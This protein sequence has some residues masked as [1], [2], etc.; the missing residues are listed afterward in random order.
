MLGSSRARTLG[1]ALLAVAS[2]VIAAYLAWGR[3][4]IG[5]DY[6]GGAMF[7]LRGAT[8][9]QIHRALRHVDRDDSG[10]ELR[11]LG[12]EDTVM[13]NGMTDDEAL[14][15]QAWLPPSVTVDHV[16]VV[17]SLLPPW[18][19]RPLAVA[20][21]LI[22]ALAFAAAAVRRHVAAIAVG[23]GVLAVAI[24][25]TL[26]TW[27]GGTLNRTL[28]DG[29]ALGGLAVL[30]VALAA[31][32]FRLGWPGWIAAAVA[33]AAAFVL[34]HVSDPIWRNAGRVT[35]SWAPAWFALAAI[36]G[37]LAMPP[38]QRASASPKPTS[39]A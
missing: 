17:A 10:A 30:A 26:D 31:T 2:L 8:A 33:L 15:F 20:L 9:E 19:G 22:A 27:C 29:G 13:V 7:E 1:C 6:Q 5:L 25:V 18:R 39:A 11:A 34:R 4:A 37:W 23:G 36:C 14:H 16:G 24:A 3:I 28:Y 35:I 12:D 38:A 21:A 32:R